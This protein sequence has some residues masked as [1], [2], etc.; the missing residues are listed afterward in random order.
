MRFSL[1]DVTAPIVDVSLLHEENTIG[2]SHEAAF[3]NLHDD[4]R[5]LAYPIPITQIVIKAK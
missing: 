5:F 3:A 4:R 1:L 2:A